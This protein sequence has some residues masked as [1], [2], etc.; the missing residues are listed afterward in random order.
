MTF[1]NSIKM[2]ALGLEDEGNSKPTS[3]SGGARSPRAP[4]T[5][6]E[7]EKEEV[8]QKK[9][10]IAE[11]CDEVEADEKTTA[12]ISSKSESK[13]EPVTADVP[14]LALSSKEKTDSGAKDEE[15][16]EE[17]KG[18][19][20]DGGAGSRVG[21]PRGASPRASPRAAGAESKSTKSTKVA[22]DSKTDSIVAVAEEKPASPRPTDP[23]V[24]AEEKPASPRPSDSQP[25]APAAEAK[26]SEKTAPPKAEDE[27]ATVP[28]GESASPSKPIS[29]KTA[30]VSEDSSAITAAASTSAKE[31]SAAVDAPSAD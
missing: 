26:A 17:S 16:K 29:D 30:A 13:K 20:K 8:V 9:R 22:A 15:T 5:A 19:A 11:M 1:S 10:G 6:D 21:S 25:P 24:P 18:E 31:L 7:K 23:T 4:T 14:S 12:G 27:S 3:P 28:Q 2:A